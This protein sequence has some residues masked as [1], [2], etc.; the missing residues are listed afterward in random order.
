M[1]KRDK[2]NFLVLPTI[3]VLFVFG[4]IAYFTKNYTSAIFY[5]VLLVIYILINILIKL[6]TLVEYTKSIL[7]SFFKKEL[8]KSKESLDELKKLSDDITKELED[9]RDKFTENTAK[10]NKLFIEEAELSKLASKEVVKKTTKKTTKKKSVNKAI[11]ELVDNIV[12]SVDTEKIVDQ[13][14]EEALKEVPKKRRGRPKK[15]D[16]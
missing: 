6:D 7:Y 13:V 10:A 11:D 2:K 9:M 12:D 5:S 3:L 8:D 16:K 1:D 4:C 14:V 15:S